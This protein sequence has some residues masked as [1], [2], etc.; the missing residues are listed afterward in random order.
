MEC[1]N[2]G[3]RKWQ[4][5]A[6]KCLAFWVKNGTAG[7]ANCIRSCPWNKPPGWM[8]RL[9]RTGIKA[10]PAL[11]PVFVRVDGLLGYGRPKLSPTPGRKYRRRR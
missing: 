11:N 10:V 5:D 2:S 9:V 7:C 8:H 3:V 6:Q 4:I 1:N